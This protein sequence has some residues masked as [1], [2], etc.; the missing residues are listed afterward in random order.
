M[1]LVANTRTPP[2][3]VEDSITGLRCLTVVVA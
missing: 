3:I 2:V 1:E